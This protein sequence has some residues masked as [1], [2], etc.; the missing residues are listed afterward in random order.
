MITFD[1]PL[2][3]SASHYADAL[4][5]ARFPA[6]ES[7]SCC[8]NWESAQEFHLFDPILIEAHCSK[9]VEAVRQSQVTRL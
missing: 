2:T 7:L 6:V 5:L 4:S 3:S 9:T 1:K 8:P